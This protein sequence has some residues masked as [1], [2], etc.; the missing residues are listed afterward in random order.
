[1]HRMVQLGAHCCSLLY[2]A[3]GAGGF[4][5]PLL[6]TNFGVASDSL[7]NKIGGG[8]SDPQAKFLERILVVPRV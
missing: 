4:V 7:R 3:R 5:A 2:S 1:M 8:A 6:L